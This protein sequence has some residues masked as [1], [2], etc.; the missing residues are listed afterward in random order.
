M[1]AEVEFV[2]AVIASRVNFSIFHS[3]FAF[4]SQKLLKLAEID[5]VKVLAWNSGSVKLL[6]NSMSE[7]EQKKNTALSFNLVF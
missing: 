3:F 5:G 4:L 1:G 7:Q 2:N 6:T